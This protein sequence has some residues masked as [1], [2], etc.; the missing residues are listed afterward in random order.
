MQVP[1]G[2]RCTPVTDGTNFGDGVVYRALVAQR[3]C[4]IVFPV[5]RIEI[6]I[7]RVPAHG[8]RADL[9]QADGVFFGAVE[10]RV[11]G[12]RTVAGFPGGIEYALDRD[13]GPG[14]NWDIY[15]FARDDFQRLSH[16][17]AHDAIF[18]AVHGLLGERTENGGRMVADEK[19]R[20]HRL[21]QFLVFPIDVACVVGRVEHAGD[22]VA[23]LDL[24]A[25]DASVQDSGLW[26]L[27]HEDADRDV[28][29][30]IL[31]CVLDDRDSREIDVRPLDHGLFDRGVAAVDG[32]GVDGPGNAFAEGG[33]NGAS[34][35][36]G[37]DAEGEAE[38]VVAAEE[39]GY[40]RHVR[41]GDVLEAD[42]GVPVLR[43]QLLL[44]DRGFVDRLDPSRHRREIFG[45]PLPHFCEKLV[46]I[47]VHAPMSFRICVVAIGSMRRALYSL[48]VRFRLQ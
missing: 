48:L 7:D 38:K 21:L 43:R 37:I 20:F 15:G 9:E 19:H 39:I 3:A 47:L 16:Q 11:F 4:E 14:R 25:V 26:I 44:N 17:R 5:R 28:F 6:V 36:A 2:G 24:V 22:F 41:A 35:L 42:D 34:G 18:V 10:P 27:D 30:G 32:D 8:D 31:L 12:E 23:A 13:L 33:K 45:S 1:Q 40:Q 29:A 46:K